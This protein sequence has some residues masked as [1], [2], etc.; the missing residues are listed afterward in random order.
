MTGQLQWHSWIGIYKAAPCIS[1]CDVMSTA[2]HSDCDYLSWILTGFS[3]KAGFTA[4]TS[5]LYQRFTL[6]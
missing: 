1:Y 3:E 2:A 5:M 6:N 4:F